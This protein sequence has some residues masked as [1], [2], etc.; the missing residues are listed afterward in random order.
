MSISLQLNE[1]TKKTH[2][3]EI[4]LPNWEEYFIK[5]VETKVI[6]FDDIFIDD[7]TSNVTKV[8]THTSQEISL[9]QESFSNNANPREFPPAVVYRGAMYSKPYKLVYGYGRTEALKNLRQPEWFFTLLEG[10][11]P[12]VNTEEALLDIMAVENEGYPKRLNEERDMKLVISGK[13]ERGVI[14]NNR[15]A[16]T[17]YFQD[18][19][20]KTR[21][22]S[23]RGRV[24][25]A[26][27][28]AMQTPEPYTEY[29][30]ADRLAQ[31]LENHCKGSYSIRG[32]WNAVRNAY[33]VGV[34]EG[35]AERV[36]WGALRRYQKYGKIT[37]V[38]GHV[39]A[40]T[41]KKS[42]EVRRQ[43]YLRG[44]ENL[45]RTYRACAGEDAVWPV[46]V[47]GFAPQDKLRDNNQ[48]LIKCV[49]YYPRN[50]M[51]ATF[52]LL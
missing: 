15:K 2:P 34:G 7:E 40:P 36:I 51:R 35:Y 44:W 42:L 14:K 48:E 23:V 8:K 33:G 21:T 38:I 25:A 5:S 16:I 24:V 3:D 1:F 45:E 26:V 20:G 18:I 9:L 52:R 12:D 43:E 4:A 50:D 19:Y 46:R 41:K 17:K 29:T 32:V 11:T 30:S 47:I 39:K 13:I 31:W 49:D 28:D 27:M 37:E 6:P 22:K 10:L